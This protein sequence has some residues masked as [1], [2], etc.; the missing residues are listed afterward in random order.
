MTFPFNVFHQL[1]LMDKGNLQ[2][3]LS[4]MYVEFVTQTVNIYLFRV[5]ILGL[6]LIPPVSM[7]Q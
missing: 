3:E 1:F 6:S 4:Y 7:N 5:N 2:L